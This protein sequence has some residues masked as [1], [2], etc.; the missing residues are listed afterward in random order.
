MK[1]RLRRIIGESIWGSLARRKRWVLSIPAKSNDWLAVIIIRLAGSL[2]P[3]V[4]VAVK[5]SLNPFGYLD[6]SKA[7]L[8]M[9]LE[10]EAAI[11]RLNSCRKEPE[12]VEWLEQFLEENDVFYDIGANVGAYSLCASA[13][14]AGVRAYAFEPAFATFEVLCRNILANHLQD[15]IFPFPAAFSEVTRV[16]LLEYSSYEPGA[17]S[18]HWGKDA[19]SKS[20]SKLPA[21]N[22]RLDDFVALFGLAAPNFIKIDVDGY[23]L[24]VL[25]GAERILDRTEVRLLLLEIDETRIE[26]NQE[27]EAF[28]SAKNFVRLE[29]RRH[30]ESSVFNYLFTRRGTG[31]GEIGP[32]H[33]GVR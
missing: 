2:P 24:A 19:A 32:A 16:D 21:L 18:H 28:L 6:Y 23:E 17:A 31:A 15:R 14:K 4:Q 29:K 22:F 20:S 26:Y 9:V 30:G 7:R 11:D 5:K 10:S 1:K 27:I 3:R 25:K 33:P 8:K 12:T 13:S